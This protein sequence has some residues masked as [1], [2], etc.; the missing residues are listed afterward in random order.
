MRRHKRVTPITVIQK[1][2]SWTIISIAIICTL[3]VGLTLITAKDNG[4]KM[5]GYRFYVATS[6]SMAKTDFK[7]GDLIICK[8]V[9]VESL[10]EG[11]IIT[12]VSDSVY[13]YG[14]TVTHKIKRVTKDVN[15]NRAFET[16][17][18]TTG[19]S[20]D[21]LATKIVGEYVGKIP[22]VGYFLNFIKKPAGY[23]SFVFLPF[24][25]IITIQAIEC[26]KMIKKDERD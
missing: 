24:A 26:V 25:V 8:S 13:S 17:G 23:I 1:V 19:V 18:T 3:I 5:F 14:E 12:F 2:L 7:S 16:Y 22:N 6:D 11:D 4:Y 15:G 20:D 10:E 21:A 9:D